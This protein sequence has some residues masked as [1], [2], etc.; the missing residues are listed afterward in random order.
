MYVPQPTWDT[1][2]ENISLELPIH[3]L[4]NFVLYTDGLLTGNL[5]PGVQRKSAS[6]IQVGQCRWLKNEDAYRTVCRH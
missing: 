2:F 3:F 1:P 4:M 5:L 6:N